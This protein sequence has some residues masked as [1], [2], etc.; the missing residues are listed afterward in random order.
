MTGS[1]RITDKKEW[2]RI[3]REIRDVL[4]TVWDPIRVKDE[5]RAQDEYDGYVGRV[6]SLLTQKK[7]DDELAD[8]LIWVEEDQMGLGPAT[9]ESELP[10]VRALRAI[11]LTGPN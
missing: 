1:T 7:S 11:R 5:P 10:T 6:F 2:K 3:C 4:L 8:F 9:R